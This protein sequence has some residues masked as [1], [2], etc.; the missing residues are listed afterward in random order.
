MPQSVPH[1]LPGASLRVYQLELYA[2][3]GHGSERRRLPVGLHVLLPHHHVE[4]LVVLVPTIC[5]ER[6]INDTIIG[7]KYI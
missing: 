5:Q 1:I 4:T 6:K 7:V 3:L 2:R